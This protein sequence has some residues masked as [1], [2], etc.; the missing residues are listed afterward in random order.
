MRPQIKVAYDGDA[1]PQLSKPQGQG[2]AAVVTSQPNSI[3]LY[4]MYVVTFLSA[5]K[6]RWGCLAETTHQT[7]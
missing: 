3:V 5:K 2:Y 1:E 7:G 4:D 6:V